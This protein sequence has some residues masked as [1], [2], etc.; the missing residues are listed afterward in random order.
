MPIDRIAILLVLITLTVSSP[1]F[2]YLIR[3]QVRKSG[4]G[5]GWRHAAFFLGPLLAPL[6]FLLFK[7]SENRRTRQG[8]F[9][10]GIGN[11]PVG[12]CLHD[13]P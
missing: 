10:A 12:N 6:L 9:S 4:H 3:R 11:R 7:I 2:F 1:V 13:G 5:G 8:D